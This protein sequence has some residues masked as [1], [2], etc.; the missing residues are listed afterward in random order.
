SLNYR[1]RPRPQYDLA[2]LAQ[3]VQN[4]INAERRT[5]GLG[6]LAWDDRIAEVARKH[7]EDQAR[8]NAELTDPNLL[9][10]YPLIRHENFSG[11]FKAGDR[12][13]A[14]GVSFRLAGENIISFSFA[15]G[16]FY[17]SSETSDVA[18]P[19]V[20]EFTPAGGTPEDRRTLFDAIFAERL[21]AARGSEVA[22]WI[23]KEWMTPERV[24]LKAVSG[25]MN[26][27]DHR[28]NILTPEF[29]RGGIGIA[30]V[31]EFLVITHNLLAP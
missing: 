30:I 2:V 28:Q 14:A 3:N 29:T 6:E 25:W 18:C 31:N 19:A 20:R 5:R 15:E 8:D 26:S 17:R 24:A 7:S 13:R 4:G 21:A 11:S 27:P 23:S 9:C 10:V 22:V 12:L 1:V 16:I